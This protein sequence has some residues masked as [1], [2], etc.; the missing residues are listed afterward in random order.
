VLRNDV[1]EGGVRILWGHKTCNLHAAAITRGRGST[2]NTNM[3]LRWLLALHLVTA[4]AFVH[5]LGSLL[6]S[7]DNAK[8]AT[9]PFLLAMCAPALALPVYK[10]NVDAFFLVCLCVFTTVLSAAGLQKR[11]RTAW[12]SVAGIGSVLLYVAYDGNDYR[13]ETLYAAGVSIALILSVLRL[14]IINGVVEFLHARPSLLAMLET[15]AAL[16]AGW[17]SYLLHGG[18]LSSVLLPTA[19]AGALAILALLVKI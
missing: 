13:H 6:G 1:C 4:V 19:V 5:T 2:H 17:L 14:P 8:T 11:W 7:D 16:A 12:L 10:L 15:A 3:P 9:K 18:A